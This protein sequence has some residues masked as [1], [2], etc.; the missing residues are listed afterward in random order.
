MLLGALGIEVGSPGQINNRSGCPG[1]HRRKRDSGRDRHS[2]TMR[3]PLIVPNVGD[4]WAVATPAK[5][6]NQA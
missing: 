1:R 4:G 2:Q 3:S 5:Q 6:Q